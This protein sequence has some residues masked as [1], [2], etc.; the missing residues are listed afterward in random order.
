MASTDDTEL[1]LRIP[2]VESVEAAQ[3]QGLLAGMTALYS[4][5]SLLEETYEASPEASS[6]TGSE[7]TAEGDVLWIEELVI[8]TPNELKLRGKSEVILGVLTIAAAALALPN[9]QAETEHM[10][11]ETAKTQVE[12]V[13]VELDLLEKA[14][15][16]LSE[17]KLSKDQ[18]ASVV[19][20]LQI[21]KDALR[22]A[23]GVVR[24]ELTTLDPAEHARQKRMLQVLLRAR[25]LG[26]ADPAA[27]MWI[28]LLSSDM[29]VL[30][31]ALDSG[32]DP[33][34]TFE[35]VVNGILPKVRDDEVFRDVLA[36]YLIARGAG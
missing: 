23:S 35:D 32:A 2:L 27:D 19:R 31:R 10:R 8:G 22:S 11:A 5:V 13:A 14:H 21:G 34:R 15:R 16:L 33:N 25:A 30:R 6:D 9:R 20:S 3:L 18:Y 36:S 28:G 4:A 26:V 24:D 12:T 17:G 29:A 7:N 1:L